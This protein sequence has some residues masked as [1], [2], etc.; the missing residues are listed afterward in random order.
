MLI[1]LA[2]GGIVFVLRPKENPAK[3]HC[4][5]TQQEFNPFE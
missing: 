3:L 2:L 4:L 1:P 5:V